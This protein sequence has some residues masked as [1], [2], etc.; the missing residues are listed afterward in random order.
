MPQKIASLTLRPR[1][2]AD[3]PFIVSLSERVFSAY[4]HDPVAAMRSMLEERAGDAAV[5]ELGG[6][7]VGFA[8][9][10]CQRLPRDF[11]PW[12]RPVTAHLDAIAVRPESHG[13]GIGRGLLDHAID[14]AHAR[15][16]VSISLLTAEANI[17]ARRL[18]ESAGFMAF[19][20]QENSYARGQAGLV[21][22][23]AL[24]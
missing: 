5:A 11:G 13:R 15:G 18:F 22:L 2:P 8:L 6:S 23:K 3:D 14:L 16:A 1:E 12:R 7:R 10:A 19:L 20:R 9:V 24:T 17:R 4:A 21:M